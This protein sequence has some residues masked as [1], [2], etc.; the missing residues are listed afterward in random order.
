MDE[1]TRKKIGKDRVVGRLTIEQVSPKQL[2]KFL[3]KNQ[4]IT[5]ACR[6]CFAYKSELFY[7][8]N[9][10][11]NVVRYGRVVADRDYAERHKEEVYQLQRE[12][13]R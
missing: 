11:A 6:D 1:E 13:N 4:Y 2:R 10:L 8:A 7:T 3:E 12:M 5:Y 9:G